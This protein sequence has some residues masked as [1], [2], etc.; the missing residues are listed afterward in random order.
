MSSQLLVIDNNNDHDQQSKKINYHSQ[1]G[2][3]YYFLLS[4]KVNNLHNHNGVY[5]QIFYSMNI[6]FNIFNMIEM[7]IYRKLVIQVNINLTSTCKDL[8]NQILQYIKEKNLFSCCSSSIVD[9]KEKKLSSIRQ[10]KIDDRYCND[11]EDKKLLVYYDELLE[12]C[13]RE[14]NRKSGED[15]NEEKTGINV[16]IYKD[17]RYSL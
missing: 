4:K 3:L 2:E 12:N 7:N 15:F 14:E 9:D 1:R 17:R 5:K 6:I 11:I 10:L 13:D 8:K 16:Y